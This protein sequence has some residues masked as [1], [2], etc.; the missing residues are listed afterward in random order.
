[1]LWGGDVAGAGAGPWR[2]S[3]SRFFAV[4]NLVLPRVTGSSKGS[5]EYPVKRGSET[6]GYAGIE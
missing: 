2:A 6:A 5:V 4:E 3:C 1:M